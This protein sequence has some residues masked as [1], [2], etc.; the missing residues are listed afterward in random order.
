[1]TTEPQPTE[2]PKCQTKGYDTTSSQ[3]VLGISVFCPTCGHKYTLSL[4]GYQ[5]DMWADAALDW[6]TLE[7]PHNDP[8]N[9][10]D[11]LILPQ[12][13]LNDVPYKE[14]EGEAVEDY[15]PRRALSERERNGR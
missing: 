11:T 13:S 1:M 10:K 15:A 12:E 7:D 6:D 3:G 5:E 9:D 4:R 2:C 14:E 8:R